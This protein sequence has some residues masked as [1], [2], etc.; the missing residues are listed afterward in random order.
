[1]R[2]VTNKIEL[3]E[4]YAHCRARYEEAG[5]PFTPMGF[6]P[7]MAEIKNNSD[8]TETIVSFSNANYGVT[9]SWKNE[10]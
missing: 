2:T 9:Y 3:D 1:M 8:R 5:K 6:Q 10:W 4:L 7:R